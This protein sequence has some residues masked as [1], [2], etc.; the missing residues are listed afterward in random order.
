MNRQRWLRLLP[1]L[2][3]LALFAWVIRTVSP[4]EVW[5]VLRQLR[6]PELLALAGANVVVLVLITAR[7]WLLLRGLGHRLPLFRLMEYRL[8]VFGLS[9]FTPGPHVGGEPLQVL[10]VERDCGVPRTHALAAVTLDKSIEFAINFAFLLLGVAL[11]LRWQL[12]DPSIGRQALGVGSALAL[13]P[14]LYLSAT[15]VGRRPLAT[16]L[17][18]LA[19]WPVLDRWSDK[20]RAAQHAVAHSEAETASFL[21]RAPVTLTLA[22][23]TTLLS[24]VAMIAEYW[25]M[26]YFLGVRL[27]LPELVVSLTAARIAILLFLPAGLGALEFSQALA[28]G[29]LGLDPAV[30]TSVSLLIRARDTLLG[31]IG[32]WLGARRLRVGRRPPTL[33]QPSL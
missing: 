28:F 24:W 16:L 32:L 21:R 11:L 13:L 22:I 33:D 3:G 19:G 9:Y 30:G 27:T 14:V 8:A 31:A 12:F 7:W 1:W 18:P 2:I 10:L 4:G 17:A 29:A 20:L 26:V 15:A 25:L 5:A 6:W 23:G